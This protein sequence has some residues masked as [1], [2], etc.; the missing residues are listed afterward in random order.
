[1]VTDNIFPDSVSFDKRYRYTCNAVRAFDIDVNADLNNS[2]NRLIGYEEYL[3]IF[4][5]MIPIVTY[6]ESGE[7]NGWEDFAEIFPAAFPDSRK[8]SAAFLL[9]GKTGCGRHTADKTFMSVVYETLR[10]AFFSQMDP[11]SPLGFLSEPDFEEF[12]RFYVLDCGSFAAQPER[13]LLKTLDAV[14]DKLYALAVSEPSVIFYF[15]LG[16]VTAMLENT[17]SARRFVSRLNSLT[18]DARAHCLVTCIFDGDAAALSDALTQPFYTLEFA[19]PAYRYRME[20]FQFLSE[21][22]PN[23]RAELSD[24]ELAKRTDGFTFSMIKQ[25]A[26]YIMMFV[27]SQVLTNHLDMENYLRYATISEEEVLDVS[28]QVGEFCLRHEIDARRS[29][30]ASLCMEE[31]AGNI[32][33]HGFPLD[34]KHHSADIRVVRKNDEIILRVRDN[35]SAFDPSEYH[36]VMQLDEAGRNIGIRLVYGIAKEITYQNLLGMNVLTIRI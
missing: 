21:R 22:Y 18:G 13:T 32:V 27:K 33:K 12:L 26:A 14:F 36:R 1:M 20:Y 4:R 34:N 19:P 35:C 6:D 2:P 25:L 28:E 8:T 30:F 16:N 5:S 11:S 29:F 9:A 24:A 3:D 31:M 17:K 7:V 23:I 15:S 10:S